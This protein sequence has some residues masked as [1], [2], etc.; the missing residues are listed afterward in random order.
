ML[1]QLHGLVSS[2]YLEC[3]CSLLSF[4]LNSQDYLNICVLMIS[5]VTYGKVTLFTASDPGGLLTLK[6][7]INSY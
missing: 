4:L 7:S 3:L 6:M 2:E 1:Q 5:H